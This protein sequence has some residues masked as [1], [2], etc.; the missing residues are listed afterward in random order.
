ME[1]YDLGSVIRR[2]R[3]QKG[4][5]QEE[6]A[7]PIIDRTTL[8]KIESGKSMPNK[9]TLRALI[10]KL[11][12]DPYTMANFFLDEND[13]EVEK[14][15]RQLENYR[16]YCLSDSAVDAD[17]AKAK[18]DSLIKQLEDNEVFMEHPINVQR[19]SFFK[20]ENAIRKRDDPDKTIELL[21]NAIKISAPTYESSDI[22][23]YFLTKTDW[24]ILTTL[25]LVYH[26]ANRYDEAINLLREMRKNVEKHCIDLSAK[27]D[28]YPIVM[29]NLANSL[30]RAKKYEEALEVCDAARRV[31]VETRRTYALPTLSMIKTKC[32]YGLG[33]IKECEE[34]ARQVYHALGLYGHDM[35]MRDELLEFAK[36]KLGVDL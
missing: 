12:L 15:F 16:H 34:V 25:A 35:V 30:W 18:V 2:V 29:N 9:N 8:S 32:L 5:T 14:I 22:E 31:C 24:N 1:L 26:N 13:V 33:R 10:E 6:L 17:A 3:K 4:I 7:F 27:G 28:I 21:I 19:V 36:D 23:D 11:G 20:A